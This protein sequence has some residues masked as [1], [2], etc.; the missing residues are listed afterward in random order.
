M[1][2]QK[3]FRY[4]E[5]CIILF[6]RAPEY[7]QV[8]TRLAA[9]IGDQAALV[10][11]RQLLEHTFQMVA[12]SQL[13]PIELHVDGNQTHPFMQQIAT[14]AGAKI[15]VQ[16]G[17]DLGERMYRALDGALQ[18]REAVIIIGTDC[19]VMD[20]AYLENAL[21]QLARGTEVV[22]GPSEDG[23][24]VLIGATR[25]DDRVFHNIN[26]GCDSVMQQTRLAMKGAGIGFSELEILWDIDHP[27]DL[28]RWQRI[29]AD[30][31]VSRI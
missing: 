22:V 14:Q 30:S 6:A 26:W 15:V 21:Q 31:A 11:Y 9:G 23:G 20:A 13:A 2:D 12:D 25:A 18:Q 27:E 19:P 8:K 7:G 17:I 3:A 4:P 24:Y 10:I 29:N 28:R 5:A 16:Q 1:G